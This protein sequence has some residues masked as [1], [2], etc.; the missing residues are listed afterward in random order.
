MN[1][2]GLTLIELVI[3]MVVII[4]AFYALIVWLA[5]LAPRSVEVE[6]LNKK[7]FLA[8][9]KIEE[10]LAKSYVNTT[11]VATPGSFTGAFSGYKYQII[12]TNVA[13]NDLNSPASSNFKNV[14]VRV[15][16]GP[17]DSMGTVEIV[18][19]AVTYE[20]K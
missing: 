6:V 10:V 9:E 8:Q 18:S 17:I 19:L 7:S 14:K 1:K 20:V 13:A 2:K 16:G 15:W 12:V 4:I 11:S 3:G 5:N